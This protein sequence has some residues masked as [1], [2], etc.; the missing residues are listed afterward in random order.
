VT[1]GAQKIPATRRRS[2]WRELAPLLI[3][4]AATA[5]LVEWSPL[6]HGD[7]LRPTL[8]VM[9]LVWGMFVV[10]DRRL[11]HRHSITAFEACAAVLL[12]AAA[13]VQPRL[14]VDSA[15]HLVMAAWTLAVGH[16]AMRVLV[17][18]RRVLGP[19]LAPRPPLELLLLPLAV[20]LAILPWS[21]RQRPPDGDEPWNLLIAHSIAFDLD[22]DLANNYAGRDSLRFLDRAL[23]PQPEDPRGAAGEI[24]S[25]HDPAFPAFLAPAYRL[26]GKWGVLA[27][28]ALLTALLAW[29]S[30]GL[31]ARAWPEDGAGVLLQ[32]GL[33]TMLP[34]L[35]LYSHQ[36]WVEVPAAL[37]T[38]LA[39][40]QVRALELDDRSGAERR[41]GWALLGAALLLLPLVK[42]RFALLSASLLLLAFV[43]V[44]RARR[45]LAILAGIG[46]LAG[47][48]Y[49]MAN[50]RLFG[51]AL[52]IHRVEELLLFRVPLH[53]YAA[54]ASGL[55]FDH[56]FG[57]LACAP[58]W[59]LLAPGVIASWRRQRR[60]VLDVAV[61]AL[62]YLVLVASRRE[63]YGGWSPPFRY[64]LAL[65][66]LLALLAVPAWRQ[67]RRARARLLIVPLAL[68]T[69]A[70]ALLYVVE[71][72]W[73]YSF[74]DGRS[75]L[76]DLL[77]S[78]FGADVAQLLPSSTRVRAATWVWPVATLALTLAI[79]PWRR[80]RSRGH[81]AAAS[82]ASGSR[83]ATPAGASL[84]GVALL[85]GAALLLPLT[86]RARTTRVLEVESPHVVKVGGHA[87]PDPWIF[88][89]RR[90]PEAWALREGER[91]S[92]PVRAGGA[93]VRLTLHARFIRNRPVGLDLELLCGD[94]AVATVR[95]EEHDRWERR[96]VGPVAWTPGEPLVLRVPPPT[97][98]GEPGVVN[99]V[100][101]DRIE[102][103]WDR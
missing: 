63:W 31:L 94:R 93:S 90:F 97:G 9:P 67:R 10:L 82:R 92:A 28:V 102:L 42:L 4:A 39:F 27:M 103:R 8:A 46:A 52:R 35:L 74:A 66:P 64:T 38:V 14:G 44:P 70:M 49:L 96:E 81:R 34:P 51:N 83:W 43:R 55:L 85:L 59:L 7:S 60:L 71:P 54:H 78:R 16:R 76:V 47:G 45:G 17:G 21:T 58:L 37:L 77:S 24:Y 73:A 41:L 88:D 6:P 29:L 48:A 36:V 99:G 69:A 56:A 87:D 53:D 19:R 75:H 11:P 86:A 3:G 40:G 100:I 33:M 5:V 26:A 80:R 30:L 1:G 91:L 50:A 84:L 20:Y 101:L 79:W 32:W 2:W 12:A 18:S 25:R 23:E 89:R 13:I 72:G 22:T 95:W 57:L 98:P 61:V 15:D 68:L 62:P 65:L